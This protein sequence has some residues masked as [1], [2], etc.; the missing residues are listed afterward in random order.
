MFM[1]ALT[2][3]GPMNA[4]SIETRKH[5]HQSRD[6]LL[7][8]LRPQFSLYVALSQTSEQVQLV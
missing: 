2:E 3:T 5:G 1:L 7:I 8:L 4:S 6:V